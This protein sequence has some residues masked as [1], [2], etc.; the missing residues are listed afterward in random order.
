MSS[1]GPVLQLTSD[2]LLEGTMPLTWI[3]N[4][5]QYNNN[6]K[7]NCFFFIIKAETVSKTVG[8]LLLIVFKADSVQTR[9]CWH[10][11]RPGMMQSILRVAS[12]Y[13]V[14]KI[15]SMH[16][17]FSLNTALSAPPSLT[18][19]L[20]PSLPTLSSSV[21]SARFALPSGRLPSS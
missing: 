9:P 11:G 21:F 4:V 2:P 10:M 18:L 1:I 7:N 19:S 6:N 20:P 12:T 15:L 14:I 5:Q 16:I 17:P 8:T 3:N 13:M